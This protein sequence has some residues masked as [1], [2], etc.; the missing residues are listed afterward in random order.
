MK[1]SLS[2]DEGAGEESTGER[3]SR[4]IGPEAQAVMRYAC[5]WWLFSRAIV[6]AAF[7]ISSPHPIDALGNWDGGW[8]GAIARQGYHLGEGGAPS[9]L[10]FFPLFPL[11]G[12][13]L[14]RIGIPWPLAGAVVNNLAFL[15]MLPVLYGLANR[16]FDRPTARFT[17]A[18]A[19]AL[20][21]S[22]FC[23]VAYSEGT[24]MLSS[25]LALAFY[26]RRQTTLAGFAGACASAARAT[27]TPLALAL[28]A[29]ASIERRRWRAVLGTVLAFGGVVAFS[30]FCY[31]RFGDALA[32]VHAQ[33]GWHRGVGFDWKSWRTIGSAMFLHFDPT[34]WRLNWQMLLLVPGGA[35]ALAAHAKRLGLAMTLYGFLALAMLFAA[36]TPLSADR[37][38]YAVIPILI[39]LGATWRRVPVVGAIV[40]VA[41][42]VMLW[43]DAAAFARFS[44]VA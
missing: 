15:L 4:T 30:L 29:A 20:P 36:G 33:S 27:G 22:L 2:R 28:T 44:W 12:S 21:L 9:D 10:A 41:G 3:V 26:D 40:I 1:F 7:L 34:A 11:L 25:A 6:V 18:T 13:V 24:F 14:I 39:A 42:L 5:S 35:W 43:F 37:N 8:Y 23:S 32:F 38:A 16:H 19:C 17:V 31:A